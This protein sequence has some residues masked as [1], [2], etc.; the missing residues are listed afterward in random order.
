V[1]EVQKEALA[2][3]DIK[4]TQEQQKDVETKAKERME[5]KLEDENVIAD[6]TAAADHAIWEI[7]QPMISN[8]SS[9]YT[10]KIEFTD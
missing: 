8:L 5:Q 2:F 6:A 3:G 9:K 4:L 1:G 10:L 7:F